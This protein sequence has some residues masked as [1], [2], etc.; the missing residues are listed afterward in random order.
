M[1][2]QWYHIFAVVRGHDSATKVRHHY[3][4]EHLQLKMFWNFNRKL[5]YDTCTDWKWSSMSSPKYFLVQ[6][7]LNVGPHITISIPSWAHI[8][9][10]AQEKAWVGMLICKGRL[11]YYNITYIIC[12]NIYFKLLGMGRI[13]LITFLIIFLISLLSVFMWGGY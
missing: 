6:I 3:L 2:P 4:W 9:M 8:N 7:V 5:Q 12:P 1:H 10:N 11:T 13:C